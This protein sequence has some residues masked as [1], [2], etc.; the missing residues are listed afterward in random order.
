MNGFTLATLLPLSKKLG[1]TNLQTLFVLSDVQSSLLP[2]GVQNMNPEE[3][4]LVNSQL[5]LQ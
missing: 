5:H 2:T 3:K 1:I 4:L